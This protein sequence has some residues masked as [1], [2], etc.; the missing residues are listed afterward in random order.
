LFIVDDIADS[1]DYKNKYAIVEYLKEISEEPLFYQIILTHNFDFHRT[2]SGRLDM[3]REHKLNTVKTINGIT[4]VEETYQ[5][6][7]FLTW[8]SKLHTNKAMLLASIPFVRNLAEYT[9]NQA[10][11]IKLTSLLHFKNDTLAIRV[12]DIEDIFKN[13]LADKQNLTLPDPAKSVIELI[14]EVAETIYQDP[15]EIVELEN[16]IVLSMAI[17]MIA[18]RYLVREI[19][20]NPF[21]TAITKNQTFKLIERF[22]DA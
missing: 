4:L 8:K 3:S 21:W 7:P 17:R 16:K 5:N 12:S 9:G 6:N 19:S 18:E 2:V 10:D 13:N 11:L 15:N 22:K 14:Y 1:F 20:D